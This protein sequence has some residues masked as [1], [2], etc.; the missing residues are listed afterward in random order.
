MRHVF[1]ALIALLALSLAACGDDDEG[2][3]ASPPDEPP[4]AETAP[5]QA[6][7][8]PAAD[9]PAEPE[10]ERGR[11]VLV[12]AL[13]ASLTIQGGGGVRRVSVV[14]VEDPPDAPLAGFNAGVYAV[15]A[16]FTGPGL[17]GTVGVWA[18]SRDMVRTGGG[19]IIGAD[20][21]TREFSELGAAASG[22]SPAAQYAGAIADSDAGQRAR[23][24]AEG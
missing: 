11:R 21:V 24:C 17:D 2:G 23:E 10:C 12:E 5:L 18:A 13:E 8:E 22:D 3:G 14:E 20:S 9:E 15:A 6:E 4:A 16:E 1:A 19:L 7:E